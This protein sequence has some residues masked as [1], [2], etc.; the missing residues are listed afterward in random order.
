MAELTLKA[1]HQQHELQTASCRYFTVYGPRCTENHAVMAMIARGYLKLD[2]FE[3]WGN[4]EQIR[5]W[6]YVNDIVSGTIAAAEKIHDGTSVNLGTM[7]R[8]RVKDC[9]KQVIDTLNPGASIKLLTDKPTGPLNRVASNA[10]AK[11][12]L[13]WAP[14]TT[15]VEGLQKTI[16]WYVH[17]KT[18]E[19]ASVDLSRKLVGR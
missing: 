8:I 10:L 13:G 15:F 7:E 12:L 17:S 5:N 1:Y 18:T 9:A 16:D 14:K 2:P 3:V 11:E 19:Q 4:G 6:T